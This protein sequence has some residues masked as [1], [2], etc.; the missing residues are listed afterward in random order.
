MQVKIMSRSLKF[1]LFYYTCE[2]NE[3]NPFYDLPYPCSWINLGPKWENNT[4]VQMTLSASQFLYLLQSSLNTKEGWKIHWLN[5][6][7]DDNIS[8]VDHFLSK[9]RNID[10]RSM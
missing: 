9:Q 7:Y 8:I 1:L 5:N 4:T 2:N 6:S 10:R 3:T